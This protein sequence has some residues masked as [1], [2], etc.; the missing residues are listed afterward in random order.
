MFEFADSL[1]PTIH[2]QNFSIYYTELKFLQFWHFCL[3]FGCHVNALCSLW[4]WDSIFEFHNHECP[5]MYEKVSVYRV[6]NWNLCFFVFILCKFGC[7]GN[8]LCS[9]KIFISIFVFAFLFS[10]CVNLVAVAT[11]FVPLKFLLAYLYSPT[12]KTLYMQALSPYLVENWNLCYFGLFCLILVAMATPLVLSEIQIAYL[13]SK[14]YCMCKKFLYILQGTEI[15]TF[16][17]YF[18]RIWLPWQ[19]PSL[20]WNFIQYI[21]IHRPRKPYYL[22]HKFHFHHHHHFL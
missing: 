18:A 21:W 10:F 5:I 12:S 11:P 13:N 1:Y 20:P 8:S 19:L 4:N 6:E 16:F 14:F 15:S 3:T 22:C 7:C 2:P 9:F 17:A